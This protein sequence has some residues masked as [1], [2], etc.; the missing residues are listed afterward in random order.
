MTTTAADRETISRIRGAL[1]KRI[2]AI[3]GEEYVS[4][5]DL[6]EVADVELKLAQVGEILDKRDQARELFD[7]HHKVPAP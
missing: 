4:T 2:E 6:S 3:R 7:Y 5:V 1:E